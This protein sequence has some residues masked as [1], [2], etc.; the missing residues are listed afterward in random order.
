MTRDTA[1][2]RR[3]IRRSSGFTFLGLMFLIAVMGLLATAAASLWAFTSQRQKEADLLFVGRQY[4]LALSRFVA[5][6][7]REPQPYPTELRQL[8]GGGEQPVPT[9]YLRRLYFDPM[10]GSTEWGLVRTPQGGITGIYSRSARTP[11]RRRADAG[12][13]GIDFMKALSYRDWVFSAA[14]GPGQAGAVWN[15]TENGAPPLTWENPPPK[16]ESLPAQSE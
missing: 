8:L 9:R 13:D 4:R 11:V 16:P 15:E 7:A 3:G 10:T 14:T 12:D 6:H 2:I 1:T 5:A